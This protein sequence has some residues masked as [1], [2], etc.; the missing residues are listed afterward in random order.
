MAHNNAPATSTDLMTV[1][2]SSTYYTWPS[3]KP[4]CDTTYP[5]LLGMGL[6]ANGKVTRYYYYL[7]R[8][9]E[10]LIFLIEGGYMTHPDDELFLLSN[11]GLDALANAT[12]NGIQDFLKSQIE[13]KKAN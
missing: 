8:Q 2:G 12:V 3:S 6:P 7:T 11:E 4:L 5:Y 13:K 9:T 1:R 10:Y